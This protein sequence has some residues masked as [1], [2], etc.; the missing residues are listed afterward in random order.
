M[1][2]DWMPEEPQGRSSMSRYVQPKSWQEF[3]EKGGIVQRA[4][5]R[6]LDRGIGGFVGF[7]KANKPI[8]ARQLIDFPPGT[9]WREG[10]DEKGNAR[11]ELPRAFF[12]FPVWDY[13]AAPGDGTTGAV[14][15]WEMPQKA[16]RDALSAIVKAWGPPTGY[17]V[18]VERKGK[19]FDTE[20]SLVNLPP[21]PMP[22]AAA[23]KW[24][25]LANS[26]FDLTKLYDGGDPFPTS[27]ATA[28]EN[29]ADGVPF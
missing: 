17:D 23:A 22:A 26:G 14:L 18:Q 5:Y 9:E 2:N 6:I 27:L 8:R 24:D 7:T 20:Y 13:E 1:S 21:T 28:P 25:A 11:P 19:G 15:I 10:K 4:R 16:L 12:A 3:K 29:P